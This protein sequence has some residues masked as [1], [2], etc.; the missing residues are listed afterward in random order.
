[1]R[2]P[3]TLGLFGAGLAALFAGSLLAGHVIV[4]ASAASEWATAVKGN[5]MDEHG[6]HGTASGIAS[7]T[8]GSAE[9]GSA[10]TPASSTA[11][12]GLSIEQ[13]NY[14][15]GGV[16]APTGVGK[17]G[18]LAFAITGPDGAA[19]TS[20]DE[21]HEKQ[22]HLIVVRSDGAAFRHV[23]PSLDAQGTWSLPWTWNTAGSYRVFADF[24]PTALGRGVTLT[25]TVD[26]AGEFA[27][28]A[29]RTETTEAVVDGYTVTVAGALSADSSSTLTATVTR[30]G[31]P[32]TTLQPYLGAFGHLVALREGDLAYLHVHPEGEPGDGVTAPGPTIEFMTE[33]PTAGTYLLYLDFKIDGVVRTAEFTLIAGAG[34]APSSVPVP[35]GT[36]AHTSH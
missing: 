10:D 30:D 29:P 13:D 21:S 34:A 11:V 9:G 18:T 23:H 8:A 15:L 32:V 19:L 33:A 31:Q 12:R 14:L 16:S 1:M 28:A 17:A 4:P 25:R 22:L 27:V 20:F 7:G 36:P 3:V 35:S 26:V 6:T 5:G 24:V 2:A